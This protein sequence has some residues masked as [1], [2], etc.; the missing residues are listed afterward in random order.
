MHKFFSFCLSV[1]SA[2]SL[3]AQQKDRP[4]EFEV[5]SV[6][7]PQQLP[8]EEYAAN[9][10]K[11]R[12][13]IE[14]P[15]VRMPYER[16]DRI[17]LR[18]FDATRT[19]LSAP[20]WTRATYYAIDARMPAGTTVRDLP[21][22]LR[23]MLAER[24]GMTYHH[25]SRGTDVLALT[26]AK[27]GLKAKRTETEAPLRISSTPR[28]S[29]RKLGMHFELATTLPGLAD[30]LKERSGFQVVDETGLSGIYSFAFDYYMLGGLGEDGKPL[31]PPAGDYSVARARW[32][33][34]GLAPLGL[35]LSLGKVTLDNITVDHLNRTPTE[36]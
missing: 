30:L 2:T 4:L 1:L 35:R 25:E 18:A 33:A 28:D 23:N 12:V 13:T 6:R 19:Q 10:A 17:L 27:S 15:L 21:E 11:F 24:F 22:M 20:D 8:V 7:T 3:A 34:E 26:V 29:P 5:V 14:P 36:N 16:M 31:D 32:L 9:I